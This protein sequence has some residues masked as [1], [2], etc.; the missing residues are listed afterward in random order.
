MRYPKQC[1]HIADT[2]EV[3][4]ELGRERKEVLEVG[5]S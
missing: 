1:L 3:V 5:G 2:V 4:I